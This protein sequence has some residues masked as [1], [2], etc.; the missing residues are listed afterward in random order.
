M[1]DECLILIPCTTL[2]D[3]PT[4]TSESHARGLLGA[5]TA[6]WHP[7]CLARLG[8]LP[9]WFRADTVPPKL[10]RSLLLVPEASE[11]R[12]PSRLAGEVSASTDCRLLRGGCRDDFLKLLADSLGE[13]FAECPP[14]PPATDPG[15]EAESR[16]IEPAD[17]F[18]LGYAWLQVQLMTRRLRY[19]S[20]LDEIHFSSRVI[21]AARAWVEGNAPEAIA[22][23]HEA[24]D[25]L[26]E[27]RDHYFSSDPSL[28]DLTLLAPTTL[29]KS[30]RRTLEAA[31]T[32]LSSPINVLI[33]AGL[34]ER[35]AGQ[36]ETADS[37]CAE[38]VRRLQAGSVGL[39]GGGP[40]PEINLHHQTLAGAREAIV[41]ARKAV[42][43]RL[44]T[45]CTVYARTAGE[46]PG[47]LGPA[48]VEAGFRG[49]LPI[50]LEAGS[51]WQE[52]SKLIWQSG[53]GD[54]DALVCRPIDAS[55]SVDFLSLAP[56]LG[57]SIDSGEIAT[58]L[59]VHWPDAESEAYRDLRRA[60]SWGLALGRFWKIDAFFR[61][62]ERPFH[63]FRGRA[64]EGAGNWLVRSVAQNSPDPLS[65]A[66]S[67]Y[68]DRVI[69]ETAQSI[70]TLA[71]LVRGRSE[72]SQ[73]PPKDA[74]ESLTRAAD[75][76]AI[77]LGGTPSAPG[78]TPANARGLLVIN[79]HP[80]GQRLATRLG[81][82]P[83]VGMSSS[84]SG[85]SV[86][87]GARPIFASSRSPE[88]GCDVT[89]DV[90]AGGFLVLA[91]SR[92]VPGRSWFRR[93][94]R[95][96]QGT[97]LTNEFM[98]VEISPLSGGVQGLYSGAQR[99]NRYSLRLV[100]Q[101][102]GDDGSES[103]AEPMVADSVR[104]VRGDQAIG[105]IV[106]KGKLRSGD[107][108][109]A[110]FETRYRLP[111]G[112][113][114][115][116]IH[117]RL[118]LEPEVAFGDDP[119]ASYIGWRSAVAG[120]ALSLTAPLRDMLH[121]VGNSKR[122]DAPGGLMIDE[123]ERH[124]LLYTAGRP[125]HLRAGDRFVDSLLIV[126]G[127]TRREF[128]MRVGIDVPEP[129]NALR[130]AACPPSLV[131]LASHS[132]APLGWLVTSSAADVSLVGLRVESTEPLELSLDVITTTPESAKVRLRFCR[133][134]LHA[135]RATGNP[136]SPW[137]DVPHERD[138]VELAMAG[139][140]SVRLRVGL[141]D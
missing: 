31:A 132:S 104:C 78:T 56:K 117:T 97:R 59:L 70:E 69:H 85:D 47:D 129:A 54:L 89:A 76:L 51:G 107:R 73:T 80:I 141:A 102:V 18:A 84:A 62:G 58:A 63:H 133:D 38:L 8:K 138:Q 71:R 28:I 91:G 46:T 19:T 41:D 94:K 139:H 13:D 2:E 112:S 37:P 92:P 123:V 30:L 50:D 116:D 26:A 128:S 21:A 11:K 130:A 134:C 32:P 106:A 74:H 72:G 53:A 24:F 140:E 35:I 25:G 57:Q 17:F 75:R 81:G 125:A 67:G 1:F 3:F 55:G 64:D 122:I 98:E 49:A 83:R 100:P 79:P 4:Q 95:L 110:R 27:E 108:Q 42:T 36:A 88:G 22:A 65:A 124:T 40:G 77:A 12:L 121:R 33:D 93:A 7:R 34:A 29:G 120:D 14:A 60:A 66:A 9:Q 48:L 16:P 114:W 127:E 10:D 99:G 105:E 61:D 52:E 43:E 23:L 44:G 86:P 111:R 109:V 103:E 113:R 82:G 68:V 115:L 136:A 90:A 87:A 5:W 45:D 39:A 135:R 20:N 131:P 118:V 126:R 6:P 137:Q 96:A 119:W 15:S 101:G